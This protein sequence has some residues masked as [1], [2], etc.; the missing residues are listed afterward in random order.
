MTSS[1]AT[2]KRVLFL[3]PYLGD[4]GINTHMLTLG[5]ELQKV[6]WEVGICTGGSFVDRRQLDACRR[7]PQGMGVP[8]EQDYVQA[9]IRYFEARI[10]LRPHRLR[11]L[12]ELLRLP[13][14]AWQ[15][16][17]VAR[18]FRPAVVHSHSQQ[19][20]VYARIVQTLQGAPFVS[21]IHSTIRSRG[22]LWAAA[23]LGAAVIA[24]SPEVEAML[25]EQHAV[26]PDRVRIVPTGADGDHFHPPDP[27]ERRAAQDHF[28]I[29]PGQFVL[30]FIGTLNAN[31]SPETVVDAVIDLAGSGHD[32]V[33]L[34]A[35]EGPAEAALRTRVAQ[36]GVGK[37]V[38]VLGRQDCRLVLWAADVLVLPS[39]MEGFGTVAVEAMLSGVV[40]MRTPAGGAVQQITPDVTGVIFAYGDH[41]GLAR[42]IAQL[43]ERPDLRTVMAARALEDAR[44]RFSS[45]SMA[46]SVEEIYLAVLGDRR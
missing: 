26:A 9:G 28:G 38:Q 14:A 40:V 33:A 5:R 35:G 3:A 7:A 39:L 18:R 23:T 11:D 19:M 41:E 22:R 27:E 37:R 31:K 10:P 17:R 44:D 24:D 8:G 29:R 42:E 16:V 36:G 1:T 20:G 30:T 25:L 34:I 2:P 13:I 46:R 32:V 21:T 6:G 45:A 4:G 12:P 43:I 15:I